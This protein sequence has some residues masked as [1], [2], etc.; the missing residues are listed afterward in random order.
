M[1]C[2]TCVCP[3]PV[4][5]PAL[6]D[7]CTVI[8]DTHAVC[9]YGFVAHGMSWWNAFVGGVLV[10]GFVIGI[11]VLHGYMRTTAKETNGKKESKP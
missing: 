7:L 4:P 10:T 9:T 8:N 3:T 5:T 2:G 6:G 1:I 11:I